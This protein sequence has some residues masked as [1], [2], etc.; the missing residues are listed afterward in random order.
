MALSIMQVEKSNES[1]FVLSSKD[2]RVVGESLGF[3]VGISLA[4]P[5]DDA[6]AQA[7]RKWLEGG[8][9]AEMHYLE[10]YFEKRMDPRLLVP[11]TRSIISVAMNYYPACAALGIAWYA[12]GKDYHD[13]MRQR[14]TELMERFGLHGR[15]FVDTA[16]VPERYWAQRGGLGWIG[17]H[18]QLV[19]PG[20][21]STFFL[22]E[23]FAEEEFDEYGTPISSKCGKC[24]RCVEACPTGALL[25]T[26]DARKC[27]SYLTIENRGELPQ[28]AVCKM[29]DTF[30][31]CDRCLKACPHLHTLPTSEP[32]LQPSDELLSMTHSDWQQLTREQYQHL[33]KGSAVKRAKYEGLIRNIQGIAMR[34]LQN[35]TNAG[36][37]SEKKR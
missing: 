16:P 25:G 20:M 10:N 22:G 1:S 30:Y 13:I 32:L 18:S 2:L 35:K 31:G 37:E 34:S 36:D 8:C 28:W 24:N 26:F 11:G 14:M 5:V 12:Q 9:H 27:L 29:G 33:F 21:G 6:Y 4:S 15:C 23:I 7:Y 19:V 3:L 17:K